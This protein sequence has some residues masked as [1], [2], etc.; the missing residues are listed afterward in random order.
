[1]VRGTVGCKMEANSS[2]TMIVES[3]NA[4]IAKE[5]MIRTNGSKHVAVVTKPELLVAV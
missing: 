4:P 3:L 1:L 2:L 5:T